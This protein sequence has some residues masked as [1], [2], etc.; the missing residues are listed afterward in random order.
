MVIGDTFKRSNVLLFPLLPGEYCVQKADGPVTD[1]NR[2]ITRS[3]VKALSSFE[4]FL[5]EG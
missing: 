1:E 3:W 5:D 2:V 4:R